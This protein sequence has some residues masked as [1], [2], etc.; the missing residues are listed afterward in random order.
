[1]IYLLSFYDKDTAEFV[2]V[3]AYDNRQLA[4]RHMQSEPGVQWN[5]VEFKLNKFDYEVFN[6]Y[7]EKK[8]SGRYAWG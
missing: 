4:E 6:M 8:S 2:P 5:I 1:M 3:G 7:H